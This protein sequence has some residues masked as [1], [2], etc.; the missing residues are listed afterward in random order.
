VKTV[1]GLA[2]PTVSTTEPIS[3]HLTLCNGV[4]VSL[5]IPTLSRAPGCTLTGESG[6]SLAI[7]I[8]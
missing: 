4:S 1:P 5:R 7:A 2:E 3:M 6:R 8:S